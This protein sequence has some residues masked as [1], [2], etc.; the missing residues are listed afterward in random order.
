MIM[1]NNN[2]KE[3]KLIFFSNRKLYKKYISK[4][5]RYIIIIHMSYY[6]CKN[7]FNIHHSAQNLKQ[8]DNICL[9]IP[10]LYYP[11]LK[12]NPLR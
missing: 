7:Q 2:S 5:I 9:N 3:Q 12:Y 11:T 10:R 6:D 8:Y 4:S 1:I